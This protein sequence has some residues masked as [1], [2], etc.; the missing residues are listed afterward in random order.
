MFPTKLHFQKKPPKLINSS[1]F[2]AFSSVIGRVPAPKVNLTMKLSIFFLL[3]YYLSSDASA[4]L[5]MITRGCIGSYLKRNQ[6]MNASFSGPVP[7]DAVCNNVLAAVKK[8]LIDDVIDTQI[9]EQYADENEN[10]TAYRE[11]MNA[12]LARNQN[13]AHLLMKNFVYREEQMQNR[14]EMS[15][16]V[17]EVVKTF[18]YLCWSNKFRDDFDKKFLTFFDGY[19]KE[20]NRICLVNLLRDQQVIDS[21]F[22]IEFDSNDTATIKCPAY[23]NEKMLSSKTE[24]THLIHESSFYERNDIWKCASDERMRL[25]YVTAY[26]RFVAYTMSHESVTKKASEREK[27]LTIL[28]YANENSSDCFTIGYEYL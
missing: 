23:I 2:S 19:E 28:K 5:T 15:S 11:C 9:N 14:T 17:S 27:F 20:T 18:D 22:L 16:I 7:R 8:N 13:M 10:V 24:A 25:G 1:N 26:Y 6:L 3:V 21:D 4:R 12:S